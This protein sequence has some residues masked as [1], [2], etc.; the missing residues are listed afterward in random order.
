M[1]NNAVFFDYLESLI[2]EDKIQ[3]TFAQIEGFL[4]KIEGEKGDVAELNP[5]K[6]QFA[7]LENRY[8]RWRTNLGRVDSRDS[9]AEV[10]QIIAGVL[11]GVSLLKTLP[12]INYM[13]FQYHSAPIE[14]TEEIAIL[15]PERKFKWY[16]WVA[17]VVIAPNEFHFTVSKEHHGNWL[18]AIR[19]NKNTI[20]PVEEAHRACSACLLHHIAMK[21]KRKVYWNPG[22]EKF[23]TDNEANKM[24]SRPQRK[25]YEVK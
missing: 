19:D 4:H 13:D 24:L 6:S 10:N 16:W 17:L 5:A 1:I 8:T 18:E 22:K 7:F 9:Q 25:A 21:L 11:E 14:T 23:K 12:D 3:Y 2:K 20:A 15:H